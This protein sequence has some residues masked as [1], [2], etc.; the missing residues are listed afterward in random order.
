M[1]QGQEEELVH[2]FPSGAA[3]ATEVVGLMGKD[4]CGFATVASLE[5]WWSGVNIS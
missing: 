1:V 3:M 2:P 5:S 4:S